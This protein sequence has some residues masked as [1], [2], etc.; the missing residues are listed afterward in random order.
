MA[1]AKASTAAKRRYNNKT[2]SVVQAWLPKEFVAEFKEKC[3]EAGVS[4]A[5]VF[6]EAMEKFIAEH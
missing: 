3:A 4:Q 5:S 2:Y 6:K 1:K